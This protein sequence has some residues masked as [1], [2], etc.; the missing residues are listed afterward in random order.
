[1]S[2]NQSSIKNLR[3][4]WALS[5]ISDADLAR[6]SE[7][8]NERLV[9]RAIGQH[10]EF[11]FTENATDDDLIRRVSLAYE[12][13]AI[14]GLDQLVRT[15][16]PDTKLSEQSGAA[17]YCVFDM[18]RLLP[19]PEAAAERVYHILHLSALAYC[20]DR[21]SDLRRWYRE[22]SEALVSPSVADCPWDTRLLYRLFECWVRLFR[23]NGWND[24]DQIHEIIA[25]LR[26]DQK[27]YESGLLNTDAPKGEVAQ[28]ALRLVALYHWA[29]ATE[30]L[31]EYMLQGSPQ[32]AYTLLDKHFEAATTGAT[33]S[34]DAQLEILL[35]W[36]HAA[37]HLMVANSVWWATRTVNSRVTDFVKSITKRAN[38]AQHHQPER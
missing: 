22:H 28:T 13:A 16:N 35:R 1:M 29:K 18:R 12:M 31:A 24:L 5:A 34:T 6:A 25:G 8:V 32:S 23:K 11:S 37:G 21:W 20:G 15:T 36:L 17:A 4:H 7:V 9:E 27:T 10:I 3:S 33:A 30:V 26:E 38:E 14:E 2:V 19:V